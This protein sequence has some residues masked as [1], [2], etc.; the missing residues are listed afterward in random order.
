[1]TS[2]VL[3]PLNEKKPTKKNLYKMKLHICTQST[4]G[5]EEK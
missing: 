1:M 3:K 5:F 2:S 4:A